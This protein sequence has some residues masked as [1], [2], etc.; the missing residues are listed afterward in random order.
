MGYLCATR[1]A[2]PRRLLLTAA[3]FA[4][5][6]YADHLMLRV[7]FGP[8]RALAAGAVLAAMWSSAVFILTRIDQAFERRFEPARDT[9]R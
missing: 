7:S 1:D 4:A 2:R 9:A 6:L 3:A 5:V 8:V